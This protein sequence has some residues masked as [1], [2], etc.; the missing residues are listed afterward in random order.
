MTSQFKILFSVKLHFRIVILN[1]FVSWY[2]FW[3]SYHSVISLYRF[4]LNTS[5]INMYHPIYFKKKYGVCMICHLKTGKSRSKLV[6]GYNESKLWSM[7]AITFYF[8]GEGGGGGP[9][10]KFNYAWAI[11]LNYTNVKCVP[12]CLRQV[13]GNI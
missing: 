13:W 3:S 2:N 11:I 4:F 12:W 1:K 10:I 7:G 8:S 5:V 6:T 9:E